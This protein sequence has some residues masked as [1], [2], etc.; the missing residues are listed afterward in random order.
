VTWVEQNARETIAQA[1]AEVTIMELR[2]RLAD[3]GLQAHQ[4]ILDGVSAESGDRDPMRMDAREFNRMAEQHYRETLRRANLRE[5][6]DQL[7][8]D[9]QELAK[10]EHPEL[11]PMVKHAVRVQDPTRF[12]ES[13]G[14][15]LVSDELTVQEVA[16]VLNL[17][18]LL[19]RTLEEERNQQCRA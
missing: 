14:E 12:L 13:L 11:G 16:S 9:V 6:F 10:L 8:E 17:L 1:G 3:K 2:F 4:R 18:L 5:A 15:R 7:K 19:L